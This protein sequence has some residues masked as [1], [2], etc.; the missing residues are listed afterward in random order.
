M[1]LEVS[2]LVDDFPVGMKLKLSP[3]G[4][5]CMDLLTSDGE[6]MCLLS[7]RNGVHYFTQDGYQAIGKS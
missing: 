4:S 2:R 3:G 5:I 1:L 6:L 7:R